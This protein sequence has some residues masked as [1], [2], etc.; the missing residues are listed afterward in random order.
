M[1]KFHR[2]SVARVVP[3]TRD[4]V[5]ITFAVPD[6]LAE[7]F[8]YAAGQHVTLRADIDGQDVR[9]SYSICSGVHD[10]A[11]RIAVK[12][13]PGGVFSAWANEALK[14]GDT[15]EVLPPL[16]HF[17]LALDAAHRKHYAAF[18]AGS[19]I[20][21]VLSIIKTTLASEPDSK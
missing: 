13:N 1:S 15:L 5:A 4:A 21:P 11:L 19:G 6:A 2:L 14:A 7:P 9:R 20:T 3:E 12:R 17:G 18:A 10:G 16:G 8:R